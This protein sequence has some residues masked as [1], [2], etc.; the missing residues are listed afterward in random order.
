MKNHKEVRVFSIPM[1]VER[2]VT[3]N[4]PISSV[5]DFLADF[6]NWSSWSPWIRMEPTSKIEVSGAGG[7]VGHSQSWEGEIVG[8]GK[9]TLNEAQKPTRIDIR[10]EFFKPWSNHATTQFV[11]SQEGNATV[12]RWKMMGSLPFFMFF[13]RNMMNA[14]IASDY[15][16]GLN[17]LKERLETGKVL[18]KLEQKGVT[19]QKGFYFVGIRRSCSEADLSA[20]MAKDFSQ[21][22]ELVRTG[23]LDEPQSAVSLYHKVDMVKKTF[24][25]TA[26]LTYA[27]KPAKIPANLEA[28]NIPDHSALQVDHWGPYRHIGN[29]WSTAIS[30]VRMKKL[31]PQKSNP[32]WERYVSMP[33]QVADEQIHTQIFAP[34]NRTSA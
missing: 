5:F 31:K 18:S 21:L 7:S 24:D 3:I 13:F 12:V 23:K 29:A 9:M 25:Y 17:M 6:R 30:S 28:G 16:R 27:S 22:Q 1:N 8:S 11:L 19:Q 20:S 4:K 10:L 26:A 34:V 15:E 2:Q 14:M 32:S 33:G